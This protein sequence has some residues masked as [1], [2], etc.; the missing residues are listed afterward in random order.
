M[1]RWDDLPDDVQKV[2]SAC[3]RRNL[4]TC[5]A[6]EAIRLLSFVKETWS[7]LDK[8]SKHGPRS[9]Q[10]GAQRWQKQRRLPDAELPRLEAEFRAWDAERMRPLEERIFAGVPWLNVR[11]EA[12]KTVDAYI[13]RCTAYGAGS[14]EFERLLRWRTRY[15]RGVSGI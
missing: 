13:D 11:K 4:E 5:L 2:V 15:P 9:V 7:S 12:L 10:F 1:A 6:E 14:P 3:V 8:F